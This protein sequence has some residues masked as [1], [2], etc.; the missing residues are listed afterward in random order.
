ME[1]A[2]YIV[3]GIIILLICWKPFSTF[4]KVAPEGMD[5]TLRHGIKILKV[6]ILEDEQELSK[7]TKKIKE[8]RDNNELIDIDELW[9]EMH[10]QK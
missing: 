4:R 1:L 2:L 8:A 7:R 5:I 10:P 9:D 3:I 6:N